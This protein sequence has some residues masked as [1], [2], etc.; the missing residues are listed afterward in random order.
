MKDN[1]RLSKFSIKVKLI[2][3]TTLI[4]VASLSLMIFIASTFFKDDSEKRIQENN[5]QIVNLIGQKVEREILTIASKVNTQALLQEQKIDN[6]LKTLFQVLFFRDNP[7]F[8]Y[9]A[10]SKKSGNSWVPEKEMFNEESLIQRQIEKN[11]ISNIRGIIG[12]AFQPAFTNS[13]VIKNLSPTILKPLLG[14]A[15]PFGSSQDSR[16]VVLYMDSLEFQ[17]A[18]EMEGINTSFLVDSEGSVLAHPDTEVVLSGKSFKSSPIVKTLLESKND[19]GLSQFEENGK[20][21][22]GSFKKIS[23]SGLGIVSTVEV[24]LAFAA[25]YKIQRINIYILIIVLNLS[26]LV[27]FFFSRTISEPIKRLVGATKQIE[28]GDFRV[29]IQPASRD[30]IGLLTDSFVEMGLGLEEKEKVKSILGNMIDPVV[31]AEAMKDMAALK[32]GSEKEITSFF[33]DVAG[34]STISEQLRSEELANLLNEYLSAMTIILKKHDGVLDKYIGDAIVGIF[35]APIDIQ[36]HEYSACLASIEMV[37]KLSD[38]RKYWKKN[39]LYSQEAQNMDARIGLNSGL[40]K[41]GFMGTDALAS[42]TMMGD[43]VNLAARLEAAGKD[44]G[45]NIL[46]SE[47]TA[48]AV[49]DQMFTRMIDLVRVKGKNEPVKIFELID[50]QKNVADNIREA[51]DLYEKGFNLYLKR[52]FAKAIKSLDKSLLAKFPKNDSG[53]DKAINLLKE[54]CQD[55]IDNPPQSDWDGVFTRTHK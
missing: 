21:F 55:Y 8:L 19:N 15:M 48:T 25:V 44:Y 20:E 5:L 30:E 16:M 53:K 54:R 1:F 17:K 46:I 13:L 32:R 3:I 9:L 42:Y 27:V 22:L 50:T 43:T 11:S 4:I 34:F 35:N 24:D 31:V 36:N 12:E 51:T 47:S 14:I 7:S 40:A 37:K 10:I 6:E 26:I 39:N 33:S 29:D 2:G 18:F 23:I 38:L 49:R 28:A 45:V 41:V 52:D